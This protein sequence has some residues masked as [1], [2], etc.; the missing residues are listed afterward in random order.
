VYQN[1][2]DRTDY[3]RY[4]PDRPYHELY[5]HC[6]CRTAG[7][8]G[9]LVKFHGLARWSGTSFATPIVAGR[10]A[11]AMRA[12]DGTRLTSRQAV[13]HLWRTKLGSEAD[14]VDHVE[15]PILRD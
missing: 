12:A 10:I 13:A 7:S 4:Y 11:A 5:P 6:T 8:H 1:V 3:C 15:L 14:A 9:D 2:H